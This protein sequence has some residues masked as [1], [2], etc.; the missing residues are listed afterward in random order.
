MSVV[1]CQ[2]LVVSCQLSVVSCQLSVV[3][4]FLITNYQLPIYP[5][6]D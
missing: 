1:S 2:W 3:S 6:F 5:I 4:W